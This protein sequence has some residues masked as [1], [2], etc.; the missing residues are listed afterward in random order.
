MSASFTRTRCRQP[1]EMNDKVMRGQGDWFV[2][3]ALAEIK[4]FAGSDKFVQ[5]ESLELWRFSRS[6]SSLGDAEAVSFV[7]KMVELWYEHEMASTRRQARDLSFA[8]IKSQAL[9][10]SDVTLPPQL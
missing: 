10:E 5:Q 1:C 8:K 7:E 4:R 3:S 9:P 2:I 6:V